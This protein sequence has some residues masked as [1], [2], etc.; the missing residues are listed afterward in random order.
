M[1]DS[2]LRGCRTALTSYKVA[3]LRNCLGERVEF[4]LQKSWQTG[5]AMTI[6]KIQQL[7]AG[8]FRVWDPSNLHPSVLMNTGMT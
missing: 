8:R 6:H 4:G 5:K 7:D 3:N 1:S 2:R